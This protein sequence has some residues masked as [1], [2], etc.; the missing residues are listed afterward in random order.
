MDC[1]TRQEGSIRSYMLLGLHSNPR[2]LLLF[3]L[4][5]A[6]IWYPTATLAHDR[7]RSRPNIGGLINNF[8][9]LGN[10][11]KISRRTCSRSEFQT[12]NLPKRSKI[13]S[14]DC[15]VRHT[16]PLADPATLSATGL[17]MGLRDCRHKKLREPSSQKPYLRDRSRQ[18]KFS[19][20]F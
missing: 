10:Y 11:N 1:P 12:R 14:V 16:L 3:V 13:I 8:E 18:P 4:S 2:R 7:D 19:R 17:A 5:N 6:S 15:G 20:D 9:T